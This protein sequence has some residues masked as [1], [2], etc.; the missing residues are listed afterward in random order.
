M[1]VARHG[2]LFGRFV[3]DISPQHGG[4]EKAHLRGDGQCA[5]VL[6]V[7]AVMRCG[8]TKADNA[9]RSAASRNI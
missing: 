3:C 7:Y 4:K 1:I 2:S 6:S 9:A 5:S 8:R